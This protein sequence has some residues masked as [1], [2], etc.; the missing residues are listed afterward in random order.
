V[1]AIVARTMLGHHPKMDSLFLIPGLIV[2][3][4]FHSLFNQ[5]PAL[6]N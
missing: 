2:A 4:T 3:I 5:F 6:V 1:F